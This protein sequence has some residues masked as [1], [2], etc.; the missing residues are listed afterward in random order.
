MT[1]RPAPSP[2]SSARPRRRSALLPTII[3][4]AALVIG[5]VIFAGVYTDFL[6]FD[7]LGYSTV[8]WRER[9]AKL[10]IFLAA[11]LVMA[12]AVYFS[13][14]VAYRARP[15]YAP[16][17]ARD[18]NLNRYQVQLEP[19]RRVVMVGVPVVFG[20]FAGTAAMAQWEKVLLFLYRVPF[21]STDPQFQLDIS[22]YT[23]TLPFLGLLIG[24]FI[25]VAVV[26]F[27]AGLLTHYLYGAVRLTERGIFTS[28]QA[29]IHMAVIAAVFLLL[30]GINF[31]LDR[32]AT[33]QDNGGYRAGAMFTD[34]HAV[35]PTKS[36]LAAAAII[37]AILFVVAAFMGR[38]KLPL[39]GTGMLVVTAIVAGGIYPYAIQQ[40]QVKPSEGDVEATYIGRNIDM[41]RQAYG[42]S[43]MTVTP[44]NAT[45]TA[46]A[47]ALR[48]DADT[49]ANIRLLDPN[50][51]S[52][53]FAQLEQYRPYYEFPKTLN[54][55]RYTID[56]KVQD[57]V[58]AVRELNPA[59]I[60]P[61]QQTWYNQHLVYTHGY[62]VVAAY[63]NTV[64]S[65]GKPVFM[66]SG[67]PSTG[68]LGTDT[69]Y[70]PRTY[71]GQSMTDYSIV[72]AP[73]GATHVEL[74]RP[75]GSST[76]STDTTGTAGE[77]MTTFTGNGGPSV[78]NW[79]NRLMYA[80]KFQS[81]DL[82]LTNG[83]NSKSQILY[84]R[85]P[86]QRVSKVAPYLTIDGNP[87]PAVVD[88]R[89]KWIVDGYTTSS[90]Y[91][92]SQQQQLQDATTD[93]L[94]TA[95]GV[96]ALPNTSVNYI[97]NSVKA[98]VDAYDGSVQLYAWDTEDP[99]LKSWENIFPTTVKPLTDMSAD[100]MSHVRY[101]EDLFKVQRELLGRYH[102]T[103]P[104]T[105]YNNT[106]AWSVPDDPTTAAVDKQPPYYLSLKMP[107]QQKTAFSL[108]TDFIPQVV[109]GTESRNILYGFMAANGDAGNVK[110]VKSPD[111]GKLQLLEL[112]PD[113]QVPGPGQVQNTFQSD[114]TVSEQLN[115][116]KL[117]QSDIKNG[118]LLTLPMGGGLLYVQPVYV[119]STG[120]TSYPTL[121]RVLVA[122]GNKIGY[123]ATL[124]QALDQ[125]FQ[126]DS[127]A[128]AGDAN[129]QKDKSAAGSSTTG[130]TGGATGSNP[131]L[132]KA[133]NDASQAMK[134]SQTAL[135]KGD[136][137]AY[138]VAQKALDAA[139]QAA[140]AAEGAAAK[141]GTT[142]SAS[143]GAT[144]SPSAKATPTP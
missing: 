50:L 124:N 111:Y 97:R 24:L 128:Q 98:T 49:A 85:T 59:G 52:S 133:L 54:V 127:G 73:E 2:S 25:S 76:T 141:T 96:G 7:Q 43:D 29:Q 107:G 65:D 144:A 35:I 112:P 64:T 134:D 70:Q 48:K 67:V 114:P 45:T 13:I 32:Y 62:G 36:I 10:I 87:Y 14:R 94:T 60:N 132:T 47:G 40:W 19:I 9:L 136:F 22:F 103:D 142:P 101:P 18:D 3:V 28:R 46:T 100:V 90:Y 117:G 139:L 77:S 11:F 6:W 71:F 137:A 121:Q 55:D 125:L 122:F 33:L 16:D 20:L 51:I 138:G 99:I 69:S 93:S 74:D 66:Q 26:S 79:F 131:A 58:I 38:W 56:G 8:F 63:G 126:G 113:T 116:L 118:N 123:A 53:T 61:G 30:L 41:T 109:S 102:V 105:F 83:V 135:T 12:V 57:A 21:G 72:G 140:I 1:S 4:V 80:L 92:Y 68:V 130:G 95:N 106:Y 143:P 82:L 15:I 91:P 42:L 120:S 108:T 39:I 89:I 37:V 27:I 23:N 119:Q 34:V 86:E 88:G 110:G 44:Y 81:S 78:G 75:Q 129:V 17:N 31:W 115:L 5:L 84:D 104:K